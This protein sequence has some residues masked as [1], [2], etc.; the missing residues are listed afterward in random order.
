MRPAGHLVPEPQYFDIYRQVLPSGCNYKAP[1]R[2]VRWLKA[3]A[4]ASSRSGAYQALRNCCSCVSRRIVRRQFRPADRSGSSECS[5]RCAPQICQAFLYTAICRTQVKLTFRTCFG[6]ST[7][8]I[9][10]GLWFARRE[11]FA[12]LQAKGTCCKLVCNP[13]CSKEDVVVE[14]PYAAILDVFLSRERAQTEHCNSNKLLI[15]MVCLAVLW[16]GLAILHTKN[17]SRQILAKSC[18]V[19]C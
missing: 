13:W 1:L 9:A 2:L 11:R 4:P 12:G 16:A 5:R 8:A 15:A 19:R 10:F 6:R 18:Q 17:Q 7:V 14:E 3:S